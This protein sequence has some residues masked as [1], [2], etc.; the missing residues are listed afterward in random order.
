[1]ATLALILLTA[2]AVD[3]DPRSI[4]EAVTNA[5]KSGAGYR[6]ELQAT[7]ETLSGGRQESIEISGKVASGPDGKLRIEIQNRISPL[8]VASDGKAIWVYLPK[9]TLCSRFDR[10][11]EE[12][13][14]LDL[15]AMDPARNATRHLVSA[16]FLREDQAEV[17]GHSVPCFVV[18]GQYEQQDFKCVREMWIDK[19]RSFI[20][21][22]ESRTTVQGPQLTAPVEALLS[23]KVTSLKL[24]VLIPDYE[25]TFTPPEN[26]GQVPARTLGLP[27]AMWPSGVPQPLPG[28][29]PLGQGITA[30]TLIYKVQPKYSRSAVTAKVEGKVILYVVVDADG[31]PRRIRILK[32]LEPGLDKNAVEAVRK[33]RFRPG[34]KDGRPVAVAATVEVNFR[35]ADASPIY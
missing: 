13:G 14:V 30:P 31:A 24:G 33:W 34:A 19:N 35:L 21:R 7:T 25:F 12:P 3:P 4:L 5:A 1:M 9:R 22:E 11:A 18:E 8:L 17:D 20:V 26:V 15:R 16:R 27:T 28:T 6:M 10:G 32:S 2:L 29:S 23:A